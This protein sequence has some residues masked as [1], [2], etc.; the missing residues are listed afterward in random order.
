MKL[1]TYN[2]P[3]PL[4]SLTTALFG[5][6][7]IRRP[8]GVSRWGKQ[9]CARR[10]IGEFDAEGQADT[11][12]LPIERD[13]ESWALQTAQR[14]N[15][16]KW[17]CQGSTRWPICA[18]ISARR[19]ERFYTCGTRPMSLASA[20]SMLRP[21]QQLNGIGQGGESCTRTTP[22]KPWRRRQ[23]TCACLPGL[24]SAWYAD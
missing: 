17:P 18:A 20:G 6:A 1:H 12:R 15:G 19:A 10:A 13:W 7:I 3:R 21:C 24:T 23:G 5:P 16:A 22:E 4:Q 14:G 11:A 2:C 8:K 9:K